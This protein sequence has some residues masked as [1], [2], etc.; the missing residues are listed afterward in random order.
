MISKSF[1]KSSVIYTLGGALPMIGGLILLPFYA[2]RLN[3]LHYAQVQFY[4][5]VSLLLQVL[6][7][8][9]VES[10]FGIQYTR[11]ANDRDKQRKFV[12][13]VSVLLLSIG[14][15]LLM[16]CALSG[17]VIFSRVFKPDYE[18]SFWPYGFFSVLTAFFNSY[19]KAATNALIY[20]KKPALF[21]LVNGLNFVATIGIS[22]GGL[23]LFPESIVGPV[24]GRLFSGVIIFVLGWYIF[25]SNGEFIYDKSFISELQ[26]F[27]TPYVFYVLSMWSLGQIDRYI[28]QSYISK[29]ELNT[30]DLVLKCFFGI[31]FLQNS[32]SAIIFPKLYDIWNK[33]ENLHTTKESNR[34]F[35]VFTVVNII[36][37]IVFCIA[38]PVM[39]K[40]LIKNI[41]FY[42]SEKYIGLIASGYALRS[43]LN[44]YLST[45]LFT[46]NT[47][48]LLKIFGVS[49]VIQLCLTY[50]AIWQ[51]GLLGAIY[52]GLLTKV[53]QVIFSS[54]F[55]RGI[56]NY[57]FNYFKIIIIPFIYIAVNIAQ[58][59][60]QPGYHL[61]LYF[62]Q[63]L[64]F[65]I[66]FYLIFRNEIKIV[67]KQYAK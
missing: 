30:Y 40:L 10:Y 39:Y 34:Y 43:I 47:I 59:H 48:T 54:V 32:L 51:F 66:L 11:L 8:Y 18:M 22:I 63:L 35:N 36:Q 15:V 16:L 42:E 58:F 19:F 38:L 7:S 3:E 29:A 53:L 5:S 45:I 1:L 56:F 31:E 49:A 28:L 67:I 64:L 27:C 6:F 61:F 60:L 41:T 62:A 55:T 26:K 52:A 57:E 4:I 33:Q 13:T 17:S 14:L 37:L 23:M 24:Y 21:L 50:V 12:G 25:N 46:K 2:N 20:F 9:S 44:F 65:G